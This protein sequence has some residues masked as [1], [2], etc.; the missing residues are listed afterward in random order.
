MP[1]LLRTPGLEPA[2]P[3]PVPYRVPGALAPCDLRLDSNEGRAPAIDADAFEG[4]ALERYP[5]TTEL[6][7]LLAKRFDL[8]PERVIVTAG[9]DDALQRLTTALLGPER[10]LVL[11]QPTFEMIERYARVRGATIREVEWP[12]GPFPTEEVLAQCSQATAMIA[13]VTPN[14]PTGAVATVAEVRRIAEAV[15]HAAVVVDHAYAE[16]AE[17]DFA[18]D[19]LD[20]P[21]VVVLR[22]F[23]KAWGLASL[24]VGYALG[25]PELANWL[26]AA[27]N[28]Y[29]TAGTSLA[30]A[31]AALSSGE[32]RVASNVERVKQE[33]AALFELA[34]ELGLQPQAS[35]ANFV[36]VRRTDPLW[37]RD[38]LAGFGIAVRAF[39]TNPRLDDAVRITCPCSQ[40]GFRRLDHALRVTRAPEALLFDLDGV[41]ADVSRSYRQAIVQTAASFGVTLGR[42]E[43]CAAKDAGDAND[44]WA[45]TWRLITE[46]GVE[47]SLEE[48]TERFEALYQGDDAQH[49]LRETERLIL[50][51]EALRDLRA[52]LPLGIVTGRPR[53]DAERFLDSRG[54]RELFD[55]LVCR[56]DAALKPSPEPL[57]LALEQLGIERAWFLGDTV[58]DLR[59]ARVAGLLPIGV[60]APGE[61]AERTR[62][63][64]G[65]AGAARTLD[66]PASLFELLP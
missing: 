46:R 14:N 19:V 65:A 47:A 3:V 63:T 39:P 56:E 23:S 17:G 25:S 11:P 62:Q 29:P 32:A 27:G 28:P 4:V 36:L 31:S 30:I 26:R 22:T 16:F 57:R 42:E 2:F 6:E 21:N 53:S 8:D 20:L 52:K 13:V 60:V 7:A 41:L 35:Q 9:A 66:S 51:A 12:A 24:R 50:S 34:R 38:A 49:G 59:A 44:D 45:L 43:L 18:R 33:R 58:D 55:V 5:K 1:E 54:V 10:E 48:V 40:A 64:L 61:E 15:P 37:L